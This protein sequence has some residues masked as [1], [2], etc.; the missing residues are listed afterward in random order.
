MDNAIESFIKIYVDNVNVLM[1]CQRNKPV[2]RAF[3]QISISGKSI[4]E[5]VLMFID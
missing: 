5:C 1:V 4:N 3:H 2:V